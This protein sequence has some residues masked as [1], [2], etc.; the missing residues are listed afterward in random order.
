M[1]EWECVGSC[2]AEK[3][4]L[5]GPLRFPAVLCVITLC[6]LFP[7]IG[8][9]IENCWGKQLFRKESTRGIVARSFAKITRSF[10]EKKPLS[11]PLRFPAVLCVITLCALFPKIGRCIENCWGKQLF[12]KESTRGFVGR[13]FAKITR[14]FAE[15]KTSAVL[16]A[17]RRYSAL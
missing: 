6:V 14:S 2:S 1:E 12:R 11:G 10:A 17:S 15:K 9:C 7:N 4:P 16:C 5:S 13:S 8:R 3:K